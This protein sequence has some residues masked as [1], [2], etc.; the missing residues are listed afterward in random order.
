MRSAITLGHE[1]NL[2]V[3]AEGVEAADEYEKL[4]QLHCD[5]GQGFYFARPM[6][7]E[8]TTSWLQANHIKYQSNSMS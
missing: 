5:C 4:K 2:Q 7:F 1:L 6:P 8:M 3:I